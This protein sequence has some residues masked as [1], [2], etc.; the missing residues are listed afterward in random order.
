MAEK[1]VATPADA[2]SHASDREA[3]RADERYITPP[4]D[5][6]ETT[7]GLVLVADLPG[8]PNENLDIQVK[9]DILTISARVKDEA[10]GA[11]VYREFELASFFRQFQLAESVD[12]ERI[13]ARLSNGVLEL[14]LPKAEAAK[15]KTIKVELS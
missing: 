2:A 4:V 1:T 9:N 12:T 10:P 6:Y 11:P 5:I 15:P 3:T 14:T 8:V 7:D 13:A